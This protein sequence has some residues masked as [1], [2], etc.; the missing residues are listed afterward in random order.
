MAD[1]IIISL[2]SASIDI[3]VGSTLISDRGISI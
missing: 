2:A 1:D 3:T